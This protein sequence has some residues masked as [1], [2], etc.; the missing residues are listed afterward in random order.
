MAI[1]GNLD[2]DSEN[3]RVQPYFNPTKKYEEKLGHNTAEFVRV[4]TLSCFITNCTFFV[5]K[6]LNCVW[7]KEIINS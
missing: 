5:V 4:S 2:V 1:P 7:N 6:P 3:F